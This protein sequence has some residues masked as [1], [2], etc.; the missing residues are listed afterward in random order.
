MP[1]GVPVGVAPYA[2]VLS[3]SIGTGPAFAAI[4][5]REFVC[6]KE[7]NVWTIWVCCPVW[8][9]NRRR[10]SVEPEQDGRGG[11]C[12]DMHAAA[13]VLPLSRDRGPRMG[14]AD[15][16]STRS[17]TTSSRGLSPAS[18]STLA[19][20]STTSIPFVTRP[21]T[22]CLPLSHGHAVGGD[23]EELASV[24]VGPGVR[25]RERAAI[26]A[27]VVPLVLERVARAAA[28][29]AGRV[30]ALDHEVGDDAMEITPS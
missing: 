15:A 4:F 28:A 23:D 5:D 3:A 7:T 25:H 6:A 22:V 9:W 1:R 21:N 11:E 27:V 26:D 30:A 29:G 14:Y 13:R 8:F 2:P 19:I 24:R 10:I 12:E 18:A 16:S 17:M 20:V